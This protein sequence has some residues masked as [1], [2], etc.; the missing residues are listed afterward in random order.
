MLQAH[1]PASL[2]LS[3]PSGGTTLGET[4]MDPECPQLT[5]VFASVTSYRCK[6][7]SAPSEG[8]AASITYWLV[9]GEVDIRSNTGHWEY[10]LAS[11]TRDY[12]AFTADSAQ[13]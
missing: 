6:S 5:G 10:P 2:R 4:R 9:E 12:S 7:L 8:R 3:V 13:R 11:V 1:G